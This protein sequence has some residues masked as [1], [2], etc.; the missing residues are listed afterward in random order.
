MEVVAAHIAEPPPDPRSVR[1]EV[2]ADLA[3]VVLKCLA[4]APA[5]RFATVRDL[6]TALLACGCAGEWDE[7]RAA[8]WWKANDKTG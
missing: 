3:A 8:E 4:K 6:E 5:D 1:P 7:D 2:P